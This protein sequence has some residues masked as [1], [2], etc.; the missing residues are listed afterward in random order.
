[1]TSKILIID[2]ETTGFQ[3]EGGKIVEIGMVEL[4]LSTGNRCIVYDEVCHE[5]GITLKD[6]SESWIIK[7]SDLTIEA[8]RHS[9]NLEKL[10]PEIER[11]NNIKALEAQ[12][13]QIDDRLGKLAD[14]DITDPKIN[15]EIDLLTKQRETNEERLK[16]DKLSIEQQWLAKTSPE[17]DVVQAI[18]AIW[19]AK[20]LGANTN[21][22]PEVPIPVDYIK[23]GG[24]RR[25]VL[26]K[27]RRFFFF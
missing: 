9:K 10:K 5:T 11:V 23:A 4:D 1:M 26:R 20:T 2:I 6:V 14:A 27:W 16:F 19:A 22:L 12:Q 18:P 7:N 3:N 8:V 15:E 13:L 25:S 24:N 17:L 21:N